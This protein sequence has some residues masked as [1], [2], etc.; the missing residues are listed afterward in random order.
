LLDRLNTPEKN[1][2]SLNGFLIGS[3]TDLKAEKALPAIERAFKQ[4][5]TDT[6]IIPWHSVQFEFGLITKEEYD[7]TDQEYRAAHRAI[8]STERGPAPARDN[9]YDPF[10]GSNLNPSIKKQKEKAKAKRK[11]AKASQK[12]NRKRK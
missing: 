9:D 7:R 3:L 2:E 4:D 1:D 5:L 8:F 12:K 11:M 10:R 6:M